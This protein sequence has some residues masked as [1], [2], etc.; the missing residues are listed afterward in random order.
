MGLTRLGFGSTV[1]P[2]LTYN[3]NAGEN[4]MV[5]IVSYEGPLYQHRRIAKASTGRTGP[6]VL[7]L[8]LWEEPKTGTEESEI[9]K[10]GIGFV[11][12]E[13]ARKWVRDL[14]DEIDR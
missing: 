2:S 5:D 7:V 10:I 14:E 9:R 8:E 12:R 11:D 6:I 4:A 13:A 1:L 3:F